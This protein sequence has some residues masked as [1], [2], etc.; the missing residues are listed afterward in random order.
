MIR[1][2]SVNVVCAT[3]GMVLGS[4]ALNDPHPPEAFK[5]SVCAV[6]IKKTKKKKEE[7]KYLDIEL[8]RLAGEEPDSDITSGRR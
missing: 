7:G 1:F 5:F 3:F 6:I 4:M 2:S 8:E